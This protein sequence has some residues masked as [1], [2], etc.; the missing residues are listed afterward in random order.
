MSDY[1]P[2][3]EGTSE[4][5]CD[6][7]S[8]NISVYSEYCGRVKKHRGG[9]S[10]D[11]TESNTITP[12]KDTSIGPPTVTLLP[13]GPTL[14]VIIQ[15]PVFRISTLRE[16]YD[17]A[18]YKLTS[19]RDGHRDETLIVSEVKQSRVTLSQLQPSSRYC[20][21]VQVHTNRNPRPGASSAVVCE[22]TA[23]PEAGA[24]WL[25]VLLVILSM[26]LTVSLVV[27]VVVKW[28]GIRQTLCPKDPLLQDFR[29]S[30]LAAP[31][32]SVYLAMRD[33]RPAEERYHQL[34]ILHP[35]GAVVEEGGCSSPYPPG[36]YCSQTTN[37]QSQGQA[38]GAEEQASGAEEEVPGAEEQVLAAEEQGLGA[39]EQTLVAKEEASGEEKQL[40]G[41]EEQTWGAKEEAPG[42]EEQVPGTEE[43][44]AGAEEQSPGAEEQT[45]G[46]EDQTRGAVED[47]ETQEERPEVLGGG[48]DGLMNDPM[49]AM[50]SELT[51][52]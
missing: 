39:E 18:F 46:G 4:A 30:L 26:A 36:S 50:D 48:N 1:R 5:E 28:R 6:L 15:D 8:L 2:A 22:R 51:C 24:P 47:K 49:A 20:V 21:Q 45:A 33:C 25:L 14:E 38:Q 52:C 34:S 16:V 12:D 9:E 37:G 19:W 42:A 32:S 11:W 43:Q 41:A 31:S 13:H 44:T 35:L 27:T 29:E 23:A 3:C 40:P 17:S 7:S 10:S